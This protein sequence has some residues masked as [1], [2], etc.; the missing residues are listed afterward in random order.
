MG[1]K[2]TIVRFDEETLAL[3]RKVAKKR[4][5]SVADFVRKAVLKQLAEMG[6]LPEED[7]RAL[8]A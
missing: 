1:L 3:L 6:Y 5:E 8:R 7:R 2:P 4:K